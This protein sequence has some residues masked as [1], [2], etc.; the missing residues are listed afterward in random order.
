MGVNFEV[1]YA[2]AMT[3]VAHSPLLLPEDQDVELSAPSLALSLP[4]CCYPFCHGG[5]GLNLCDS[6]AAS[7]KMFLCKS[8]HGHGVSSQQ[9]KPKLRHLLIQRKVIQ[10]TRAVLGSV[11]DA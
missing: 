2:Q 7:I 8:C 5:N 10:N 9:W 11:Q 1:S 6:K 3:S 4:T